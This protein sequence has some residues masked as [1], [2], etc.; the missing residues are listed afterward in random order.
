[1]NNQRKRHSLSNDYHSTSNH[2]NIDISTDSPSLKVIDGNLETQNHIY[3]G[4]ITRL[5]DASIFN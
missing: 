4:T 3:H 1:M 2:D 5:N